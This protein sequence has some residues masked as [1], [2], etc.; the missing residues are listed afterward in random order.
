MKSIEGVLYKAGT[1][2]RV[3]LPLGHLAAFGVTELSGKTTLIEAAIMAAQYRGLTFRTKRGELGFEGATRLPI[4]FEDKGLTH[5]KNLEG[6]MSATFNERIEREPGIR[7]AI[8]T[9]CKRPTDA[10]TLEEILERAREKQQEFK[11]G[12]FKEEVFG[13]LVNYL[14]EVL[15]QLRR[16]PYTDE[17]QIGETGL[18]VMD[19]VGLSDEM[20]N[21]IIA[22]VLRK[23]YSDISDVIVVLPEVAKFIP[24]GTG[25]PVKWM[26]N[27][28]VS[29]GR[30]VGDYVWLD[31]QNLKSVDKQ[32]LR[33]IDTRLFGRQ[34]D[35][36]EIKEMLRMLP[37]EKLRPEQIM[38][39]K[40]GHFYA[41]LRDDIVLVYARPYWL[42][43]DIAVKV[44]RGELE[45]DS[46]EVQSFKRNA[47][48]LET[49]GAPARAVAEEDWAD[50]DARI[51]QVKAKLRV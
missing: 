16:T 2:E 19:L 32:P 50:V 21:L 23:I 25:S 35:A 6:L 49:A 17:L 18:Y 5:W 37:G 13:K 31:G 45:A 20:Q 11:A 14:E 41:K 4:Y 40:V 48:Q 42:P 36:Y 43:I 22:S 47:P 3:G 29:E 12:T 30:S 44:A 28:L 1:G 10:E 34:P 7:Y 26:F 15:P 9:V 46:E 51:A 24:S 39:L 38:R 33:N 27:R 8:Q